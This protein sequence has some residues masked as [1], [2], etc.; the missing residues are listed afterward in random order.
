[1]QAIAVIGFVI[2]AIWNIVSAVIRC[3]LLVERKPEQWR[4]NV[5]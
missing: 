3:E 1:M 4:L 5:E 2:D